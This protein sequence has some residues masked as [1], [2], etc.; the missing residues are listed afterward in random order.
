MYITIQVLYST[1]GFVVETLLSAMKLKN[2]K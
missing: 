1:T 2:L